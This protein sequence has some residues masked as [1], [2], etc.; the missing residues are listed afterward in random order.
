MSKVVFAYVSTKRLSHC[1]IAFAI[2]GCVSQIGTDG[3]NAGPQIARVRAKSNSCGRCLLN[4]SRYFPRRMD[5]DGPRG[6]P[7]WTENINQTV[8]KN[9]TDAFTAIQGL[10]ISRRRPPSEYHGEGR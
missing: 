2:F 1:V 4:E 9:V 6:A 10:G 5:F 7:L 3:G 8:S